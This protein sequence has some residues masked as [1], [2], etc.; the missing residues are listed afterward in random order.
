MTD[1]PISR[2][3]INDEANK[4]LDAALGPYRRRRPGPPERLPTPEAEETGTDSGLKRSVS[5]A[6]APQSVRDGP[7]SRPINPQA[8]SASRTASTVTTHDPVFP[9]PSLAYHPQGELGTATAYPK[10]S[11]AKTS[12]LSVGDPGGAW[13]G[14][15]GTLTLFEG[16]YGRLEPMGSPIGPSSFMQSQYSDSY[17]PYQVPVRSQALTNQQFVG[18]PYSDHCP[19]PS[20]FGRNVSS[21]HGLSNHFDPTA[22]AGSYS[23]YSNPTIQPH[24][25]QSAGRV[26]RGAADT[27]PFQTST[28][29]RRP[30]AQPWRYQSVLAPGEERPDMPG[31]QNDVHCPACSIFSSGSSAAERADPRLTSRYWKTSHSEKCW[32]GLSSAPGPP[33]TSS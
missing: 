3:Q 12:P 19:T 23:S 11:L 10:Q 22:Q 1:Q 30:E 27:V 2:R 28:N 33:S 21:N 8:C 5:S 17:D 14:D 18:P 24:P 15:R 29:T 26:P 25:D 13:H 32:L 4:A 16:W 6:S 7:H 20:A 9:A 31:I